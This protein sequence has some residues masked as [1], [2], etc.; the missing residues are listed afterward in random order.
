MVMISVRFKRKEKM[1][2]TATWHRVAFVC[3]LLTVSARFD[4]SNAT[5]A[6]LSTNE[7]VLQAQTAELSVHYASILFHESASVSRFVGN[8]SYHQRNNTN[9]NPATR[10]LAELDWRERKRLRLE[11]EAQ[12]ARVS[13]HS[14]NI[15][16]SSSS[17]G[18]RAGR[19]HASE[20]RPRHDSGSSFLGRASC[21]HGQLRSSSGCSGGSAAAAV[22]LD[23]SHSGRVVNVVPGGPPMLLVPAPRDEPRD[24]SNGHN[25][26]TK[27]KESGGS[28]HVVPN[29]PSYPVRLVPI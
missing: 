12:E 25:R 17:V 28:H 15:D 19:K 4:S 6:S 8:R 23:Q 26:R 29:T 11:R 9:R 2:P 14:Q 13:S 1:Q 22:A 7:E 10:R 20:Q 27:E 18:T 3:A 5:I 21:G 16:S 24:G